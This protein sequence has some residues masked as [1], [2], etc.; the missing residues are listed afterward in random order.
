MWSL[1]C[2]LGDLFRL[3]LLHAFGG[4]GGVGVAGYTTPPAFP[5]PLAAA[6]RDVPTYVL[7]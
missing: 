6:K 2:D 5:D 1:P 7:G 3:H 4:G